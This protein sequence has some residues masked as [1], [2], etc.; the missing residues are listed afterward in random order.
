VG[1][2]LDYV[3][4]NCFEEAI[5]GLIGITFVLMGKNTNSIFEAVFF[6]ALFFYPQ[7]P[8][9][10]S[11]AGFLL[12]YPGALHIMKFFELPLL[13][14]HSHIHP[15]GAPFPE[16]KG[17]G[18]GSQAGIGSHQGQP[19]EGLCCVKPRGKRLQPRPRGVVAYKGLCPGRG[20]SV[21][22]AIAVSCDIDMRKYISPCVYVGFPTTDL[23]LPGQDDG[24]GF[25]TPGTRLTPLSLGLYTAQPLRG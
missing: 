22:V 8:A 21:V 25:P 18:I 3:Y 12:P 19:R 5:Y 20:K 7:E 10:A 6:V 4:T 23:P 17:G 9:T 14:T 11:L 24:G 1:N 16:G 2:K 15:H 13:E